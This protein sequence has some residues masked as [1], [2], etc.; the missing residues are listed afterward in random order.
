MK[1][2]REKREGG[3]IHRFTCICSVFF[4]GGR[5]LNSRV[6]RSL[7]FDVVP[8][9]DLNYL[10]WLILIVIELSKRG[11]KVYPLHGLVLT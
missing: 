3:G 6:L 1:C 10:K 4:G 8:K 9:E 11:C 2:G 5:H 7:C